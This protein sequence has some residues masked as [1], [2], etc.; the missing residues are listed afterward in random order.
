LDQHLSG[1][2]NNDYK[3]WTVLMLQGWLEKRDRT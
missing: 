3:L 2:R 1:A